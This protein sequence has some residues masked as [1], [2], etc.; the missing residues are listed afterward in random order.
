VATAALVVVSIAV[1]GGVHEVALSGSSKP[2]LPPVP[3]DVQG[4]RFEPY[5]KAADVF[6]FYRRTSLVTGGA[7]YAIRHNGVVVGTLEQSAFKE[8]PRERPRAL[9]RGVLEQLRMTTDDLVRLSGERVY[10]RTL[11]EQT[12]YL[13]VASDMSSFQLVVATRQMEEADAVFSTLLTLQRGES[14]AQLQRPV[15][16]P[17]IDPRRTTP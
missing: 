6:D 16:R 2:A 13:W 11:P 4:Y 7:F 5:A 1:T 17:P 8:G 12:E 10:V 14:G 9:L 15:D 3:A